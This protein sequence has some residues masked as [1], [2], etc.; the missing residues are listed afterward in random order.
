MISGILWQ[1]ICSETLKNKAVEISP[2]PY[3]TSK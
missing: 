2:L 1:F 3:Y